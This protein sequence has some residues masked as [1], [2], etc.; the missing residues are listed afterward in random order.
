MIPLRP[1]AVA[2]ISAENDFRAL[3]HSRHPANS[4]SR[5]K[6][7]KPEPQPHLHA[8]FLSQKKPSRSL[9]TFHPARCGTTGHPSKRSNNAD[10]ATPRRSPQH[11]HDNFRKIAGTTPRPVAPS[12]QAQSP[13]EDAEPPSQ[14]PEAEAIQ[15]SR[16]ACTPTCA[17]HFARAPISMPA[18]LQPTETRRPIQPESQHTVH[19]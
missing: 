17:I 3:R 1:F 10:P 14:S 2:R 6:L 16:Q 15:A 4:D 9:A 11:R 18:R 8:K 19:D 7:R 5:E 12:Q 13:R